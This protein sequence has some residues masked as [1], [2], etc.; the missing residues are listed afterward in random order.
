LVSR[1]TPVVSSVPTA[2]ISAVRMRLSFRV[3]TARYG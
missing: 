1:V 2:R 3:T